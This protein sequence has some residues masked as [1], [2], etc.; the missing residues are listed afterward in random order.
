MCYAVPGRIVARD[1]T[2]GVVDYCG[3]ERRVRIYGEEAQVG[4]YVYVQGGVIVNTLP[5]A[6]AIE[7]LETWK[8]MLKTLRGIDRQTVLRMLPPGTKAS[9]PELR[10]GRQG[11]GLTHDEIRNLLAEEDPADIEALYGEANQLRHRLHG[12]ACCVHGIIEFSNV[13]HRKCRYCGIRGPASISRYRMSPDEIVATASHAAREL[14]FKALVLQ[15]GEDYSYDRLV[16]AEIVRR[17]RQLNVLV[18]LSIG[19]RSK[20]TYET[21]FE[22]GARAAL[23][24]FET[25]NESLFARHRPGTTLEERLALIRHLKGMGYVLATGF[26]VG[27]P[28]ETVDDIALNIAMT[29]SLQPDMYSFGPFLPVMHTPLRGS[30]TIDA[31]TVLKTIAATRLA[32]PESNILVTTALETLDP[33]AREQAL[34]AGANSMMINVT[35]K[36]FRPLYSIYENRACVDVE[37]KDAVERTVTDLKRLGRAPTDVG[38]TEVR[39]QTSSLD[40][41]GSQ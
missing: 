25:S 21:L 12:N 1:E 2:A 39:N 13:C 15:S 29:R 37:P 20:Q 17:V 16:L 8:E 30:P 27:L 32:C 34:L 35:P 18:F 31:Q 3:E 4:D 28:G 40:M 41:L 10:R 6:E 5:E 19:M 33:S 36:H 23:L 14:G 26:L 24:R 9:R 22:A 11:D 38:A 7:A